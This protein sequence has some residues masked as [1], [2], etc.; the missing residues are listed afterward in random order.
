MADVT[1]GGNMDIRYMKTGVTIYLPCLIEGCGLA[2]G[3]F[4][5]AQGD[6]E[7]SGTAIEMDAD[8]TVTTRVIRDGQDLPSRR[9]QS[10]RF[11]A[12]LTIQAASAANG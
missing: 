5:Y 8:I 9:L 2:I 12:R 4:H 10:S 11:R 6:G 1:V 3:D 7:V